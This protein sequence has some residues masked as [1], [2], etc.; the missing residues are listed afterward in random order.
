[1]STQLS[2]Q[3]DPDSLKNQIEI[4]E[5]DIIRAQVM[6]ELTIYYI[7]NGQTD[8]ALMIAE[9]A[10]SLSK[11]IDYK[12]GEFVSRWMRSDILVRKDKMEAKDSLF[13]I[14]KD[15]LKYGDSTLVAKSY[16]QFG[17]QYMFYHPDLKDTCEFIFKESLSWNNNQDDQESM[18]SYRFLAALLHS[19]GRVDE[20]LENIDLSLQIDSLNLATISNKIMILSDIGRPAEAIETS[21]NLVRISKNMVGEST[22]MFYVQNLGLLYAQH[23]ENE[24]A[25]ENLIQCYDY[26]QSKGD[27]S[28]LAL[29]AHNLGYAYS[30]LEDYENADRYFR[31]SLSIYEKNDFQ[32]RIYAPYNGVGW[33]LYKTGITDSAQYYLNKSI[34]SS[35][36]CGD[37]EIQSTS[38]W[39]L[40]KIHLESEKLGAAEKALNN[41]YQLADG[42]TNREK[43]KN[44]AESLYELHKKKGNLK[45]ALQYHE[46]FKA[47]ADSI[48]NKEQTAKIARLEA[49]FEHNQQQDALLAKQ[50]N[51]ELKLEAEI[52]NRQSTIYLVTAITV[53]L[54][55]ILFAILFIYRRTRRKNQLIASQNIKLAKSAQQVSELSNFKEGLTHMI[56]HDMKNAL[57]TILGFAASDPY[58]KKMHNISQSG[59][60]MLNLV[61]NMLD[62]QR[63]E[64]AKVPLDLKQHLISELS[65]DAKSQVELLLQMKSLTLNVQIQNDDKILVDKEVMTR[66]LV[67]LLTNAIKYSNPGANIYLNTSRNQENKAVISITDEGSGISKEKL[68]FLFERFWQSDAKASGNAASTGLGLAFCKLAIEAHGGEIQVKSEVEI[69]STFSVVVNLADESEGIVETDK[70]SYPRVEK[71]DHLTSEEAQMLSPFY[72]ELMALEVFEVGALNKLF[73]RMEQ[74]GVEGRWFSALRAAVYHADEELFAS[75]KQ[76]LQVLA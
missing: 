44:S 1:M 3:R 48:L 17:Y 34:Q 46:I 52:A 65:K 33:V 69:G 29:V 28:N 16:N 24:K 18:F 73:L 20:A 72:S 74:N 4:L 63:F 67:N 7:I 57:N 31:E 36:K 64:E 14:H 6:Q 25:I 76:Q 30:N 12:R 32:C 53:I 42:L 51:E 66:V 50:R 60:L 40:G 15:A 39:V 49:D 10:I 54:V 55:I 59:H 58:N 56:A 19:Y 2:A 38:W 21:L 35:V 47:N 75:L 61:T 41:A 43:I 70:I 26:A 23:G 13:S 8:S 45:L 68:P 5:D 22:Y 37:K 27:D 71:V 11:Q 62:V 9:D